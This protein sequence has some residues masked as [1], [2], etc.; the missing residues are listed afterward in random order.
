[1]V[2]FKGI[3]PVSSFFFQ[4][5]TVLTKI[6]KAFFGID[7]NFFSLLGEFQLS[8][9]NNFVGKDHPLVFVW[10]TIYYTLL[11]H[12]FINGFASKPVNRNVNRS[13]VATSFSF[14]FKKTL[15]DARLVVL[16]NHYDIDK[17]I[18]CLFFFI[19][20]IRIKPRFLDEMK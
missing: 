10:S 14:P 20:R 18:H 16:R 7:A 9:R 6:S 17:V 4:I 8:N 11:R 1:M 2:T 19:Y 12:L 13:V 5:F 3:V 15:L